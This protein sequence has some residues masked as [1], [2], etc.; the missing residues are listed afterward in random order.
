[1]GQTIGR[2]FVNPTELEE[3]GSLIEALNISLRNFRRLFK[4]FRRLDKRRTGVVSFGDIA[5]LFNTRQ[6]EFIPK[7]FQKFGTNDTV[8]FYHF[9]C[10]IWNLCTMD[11]DCLMAFYFSLFD[12]DEGGHLDKYAIRRLMLTVYDWWR[13]YGLQEY[14]MAVDLVLPEDAHNMTANEFLAFANENEKL[15]V[16]AFKLQQYIRSKFLGVRAWHRIALLDVIMPS[17]V[18][19]SPLEFRSQNLFEQL[20][21]QCKPNSSY[22]QSSKKRQ[23]LRVPGSGEIDKR[24]DNHMYDSHG[25]HFPNGGLENPPR[26][27]KGLVLPYDMNSAMNYETSQDEKMIWQNRHNYG[28]L[29]HHHNYHKKSWLTGIE[30][31]TLFPILSN[32]VYNSGEDIAED[33]EVNFWEAL[34]GKDDIQTIELDSP[35]EDKVHHNEHSKDTTAEKMKSGRSRKKIRVGGWNNNQENDVESLDEV[36]D[37]VMDF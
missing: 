21:A 33:P 10:A 25:K 15:C 17:G 6:K 8:D 18:V 7:V 19:I 31:H 35:Q 37:F 20:I 2:I 22:S 36:Q 29:D 27:L 23:S 24:N 14:T 30:R 34:S 9:V 11:K 13:S 5:T 12:K 3:Y 16:P 28:G 1:M 32:K 4:K 26:V